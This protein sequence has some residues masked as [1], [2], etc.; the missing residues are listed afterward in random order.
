MF[1]ELIK[2]YYHKKTIGYCYEVSDC[3]SG[4]YFQEYLIIKNKE[5]EKLIPFVNYTIDTYY[6][7]EMQIEDCRLRGYIEK[8][9]WDEVHKE[10]QKQI[11]F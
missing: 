5:K 4:W 1:E 8:E 11:K 3:L 9:I 10:T 6:E 7:R 2:K